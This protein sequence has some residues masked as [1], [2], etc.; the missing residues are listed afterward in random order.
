MRVAVH[1]G[2]F[3]ADDV[4]A[5]AILKKVFPDM[6]VVRTRDQDELAA[7][8]MRVDVG[9]VYD[10]DQLSYDHHQKEGAGLR[11][12][13]IAYAS[14][15]L[16]WKHY[17]R[18]LVNSDKAWDYIETKIIQPIDASD[19]GVQTYDVRTLYPYTISSFVRSFNPSWQETDVDFDTNFMK[20]V[21]VI[22]ELLSRE[23]L[24]ANGI[25][26][27]EKVVL[28]SIKEAKS[29]NRLYMILKQ[30]CPWKKTA[31]DEDTM[32]Y[33]VYQNSNGNWY[34]QAIPLDDESFDNRKSLPESWAG[35]GGEQLQEIS[36]VEDA[37]FCHRMRFLCA[38]KSFEG[39]IALVEK[40]IAE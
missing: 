4:F 25:T 6:E 27:A 20:A 22:G 21:G 33:C 7:A 17:G 11:G 34:V 9:G 37:I 16:I 31:A 18:R 1:D 13:D 36:G 12:K 2:S 3:H 38:A 14:A 39:A 24:K 5:V 8:D 23:F 32:L 30:F 10:H 29:E 26:E 40:A 35:L 19:N 15:G 28:D